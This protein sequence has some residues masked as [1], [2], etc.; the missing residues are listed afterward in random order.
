MNTPENAGR[1]LPADAKLPC[2]VSVCKMD[3]DTASARSIA[4][5]TVNEC[6]PRKV[7]E[8]RGRKNR[9]DPAA[10]PQSRSHSRKLS[11]I[12]NL[13]LRRRP[14]TRAQLGAADPD[15]SAR[16]STETTRSGRSARA[17]AAAQ[18]AP[19]RHHQAQHSFFRAT[20]RVPRRTFPENARR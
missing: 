10:G 7:E 14:V 15:R 19:T 16:P 11:A 6:P 12:G 5:W 2:P 17:R 20:C 13:N 18:R 8:T 3:T 1:H 4:H 9:E